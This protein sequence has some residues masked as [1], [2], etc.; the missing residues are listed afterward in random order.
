M[1]SG[2]DLCLFQEATP[3]IAAI[4]NRP[5]NTVLVI[6]EDRCKA[7]V[8]ASLVAEWVEDGHGVPCK[9]AGICQAVVACTHRHL[10]R[11]EI[12]T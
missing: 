3:L 7:G 9:L 4:P 1:S 5:K 2:R 10:V 12:C 8:Q 11:Q 6:G